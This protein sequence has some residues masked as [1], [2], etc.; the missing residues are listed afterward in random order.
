MEETLKQI[1][2]KIDALVERIDAHERSNKQEFME[3]SKKA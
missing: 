3:L 2:N 1:L